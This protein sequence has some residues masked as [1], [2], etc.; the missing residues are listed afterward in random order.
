VPC[1]STSPATRST[2]AALE[3]DIGLLTTHPTEG[4]FPFFDGSV[5]TAQRVGLKA[6]VPAHYACF[7]KRNYDPREWAAQFPPGGPEPRIIPYNQS[8]VYSG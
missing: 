2:L 5:R 7:V 1:A 6:A 3:P 8:I 4:E